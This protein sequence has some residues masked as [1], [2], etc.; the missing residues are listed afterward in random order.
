MR[1]LFAEEEMWLTSMLARDRC[2]VGFVVLKK[3][4][5]LSDK[6]LQE[7]WMRRNANGKHDWNQGRFWKEVIQDFYRLAVPQTLQGLKNKKWVR[8]LQTK[9]SSLTLFSK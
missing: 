5:I 6:D 2:F 4:K 3:K 9:S 7:I 1:F 8:F